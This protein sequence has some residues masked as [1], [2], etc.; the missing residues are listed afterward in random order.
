MNWR[1]ITSYPDA[2][3]EKKWL[4]FL[5]ASSYPSHYTSPGYFK[6]SFREDQNPFAVLVIDEEKVLAAA[7]G[8]R[9]GKQIFSG[10]AVRP[11]VSVSE[12]FAQQEIVEAL[13]GG[14]LC[15]T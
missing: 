14:F 15:S 12:T 4:D 6:E 5:P 13:R 11:Q 10:L 3:L 9:L 1:I 2:D 7:T 8:L